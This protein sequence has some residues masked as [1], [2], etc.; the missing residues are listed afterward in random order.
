MRSRAMTIREIGAVLLG[1]LWIAAGIAPAQAGTKHYY[2]TDAQGTVLAKA[3]A[4]G[5]I[6]ATYDY[7]P[8][9]TQVLGTPP[10]GPTG[11]TGHVNDAES[12]LVYMQAR[13]YDPVVGRFLSVDPVGVSPGDVFGLNRYAYAS[14]NPIINI[15]PDG[16]Q[17]CTTGQDDQ[18]SVP[19]PQPS[20]STPSTPPPQPVQQF[21]TVNVTANSSDSLSGGV[22][23]PIFKLPPSK[24]IFR[25][26]WTRPLIRKLDDFASGQLVKK[27]SFKTLTISK[28]GFLKPTPIVFGVYLATHSEGL[29]GCDENGV[30][31]DEVPRDSLS[32]EGRLAWDAQNKN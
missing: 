28:E 32:E 30:C 26:P 10:S 6:V 1:L 21:P 29:G 2:Y 25:T 24:P 12:G 23:P 13:Y 5:N 20:Q 7:A 27:L 14:N 19:C 18:G 15:D 3:D 9:G 11:Y 16:M 22:I 17:P 8:Y 4:Q 31:A